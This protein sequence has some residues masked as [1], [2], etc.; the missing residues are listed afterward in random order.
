M[1]PGILVERRRAGICLAPE[2]ACAVRLVMSRLV[3][4]VQETSPHSLPWRH[5]RPAVVTVVH[6]CIVWSM[7]DVRVCVSSIEQ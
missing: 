2:S 6:A 3:V 5:H 7:C 4:L 1:Q